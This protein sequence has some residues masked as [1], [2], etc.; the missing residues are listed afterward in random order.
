[1]N[2][3]FQLATTSVAFMLQLSRRQSNALLRVFEASDTVDGRHDILWIV[4]PD[5]LRGLERKGLV[6]W[7]YDA[8]GDAQGF[9][10]LTK[11]GTLTAML[12]REAGLTVENTMTNIVAKRV[13][14]HGERQQKV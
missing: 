12:L 8:A 4:G 10:G 3:R 2:E 14:R 5:G 9:G 7:K 1:V 13:E 11:A 6:F